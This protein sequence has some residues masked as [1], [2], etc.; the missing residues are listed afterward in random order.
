MTLVGWLWI[1]FAAA[2]ALPGLIVLV[3]ALFADRSRGRKRCPKCW[4][5][6]SGATSLVCTECGRDAKRERRL[7]RTRRHWKAAWLGLVLLVAGLGSYVG[8]EVHRDGWIR[9]TPTVAYIVALPWLDQST[10]LR[11]LY[12]RIDSGDLRQWEYR[13]LV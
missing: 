1:I 12:S 2:F 6:M 10:T 11:E 9:A 3:R 13:L 7:F 4:Y 5:D 8:G